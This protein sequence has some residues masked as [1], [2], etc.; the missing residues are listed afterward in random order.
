VASDRS[1]PRVAIIGAGMSGVLMGYRL[2]Q[3]GLDNFTIYEKGDSCGGTWRENTYPGLHCDVA[4]HHYRY[5][6]APNP[7][8][9]KTFP[10]GPEI[11]AYFC[12]QARELGVEPHIRFGV[13]VR[14]ARWT[15][16]AWEIGLG[17]GERDRADI[18]VSATGFL[19]MLNL[20]DIPGLDSFAGA[21]FHSAR[22]DHAIALDDK[23]VGVIGTGS[24]A[25]QITSA[26]AGAVRAYTLFQRTPQWV[27]QVPND[28]FSAEQMESFRTHPGTM[29]A[30]YD[31]TEQ[32]TQT[33][34][35]GIMFAD[36]PV[37]AEL[38][39]NAEQNLAQIADPD[40]RRR[41][42]PD[43]PLGCKR[44]IFSPNFYE[45]IQRPNTELVDDGIARVVPEGIVT[46]SGRLVELDVLVLATGFN[47]QA[48]IRPVQLFG[49]DGV[50]LDDVWAKRPIAYQT[51]M[52]P[53]MPNFFMIGGPYSPVGNISLV[54]VSELQSAWIMECVNHIAAHGAAIEPSASATG[55]MVADFREAAMKTVWAQGGCSSW[56]LDAEGVPGIYPYPAVK[57]KEDVRKGPNFADFEI[58]PLPA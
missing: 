57:F 58:A 36:S 20:P 49:R 9:T 54:L 34:S 32:M 7:D 47:A 24:T 17:H 22:W 44:L 5:S 11:H 46:R 31:E 56:Y 50:S 25:T 1:A 14:E 21:Q 45:A 6:F 43:Y 10:P 23:R 2:L 33:L 38:V 29:Q 27:L 18:L 28:P 8:W 12:R 48:Y 52:V 13:E 51:M 53:H 39:G 26:L 55:A 37:R 42:T 30:I 15:G 35:G 4:S 41:L 16:R 3:A 19:H 40:L